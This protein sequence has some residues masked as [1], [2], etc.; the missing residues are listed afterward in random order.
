MFF[1]RKKMFTIILIVL[2]SLTMM[3]SGFVAIFSIPES[4]SGGSA[5]RESLEKEFE[6]RRQLVESISQNLEAEPE[7]QALRGALADAWMSVYAAAG[8]LG[9]AEADDALDKAL[10]L[11]AA[12]K[13]E[14][15]AVGEAEDATLITSY[16][17]AAFYKRDYALALG[18]LS[19]LTAR[20]PENVEALTLYGAC[21]FY[22]PADYAQAETLWRAA[23][24]L[25][26]DDAEREALAYY[27]DMARSAR[28]AAESAT[29][30]NN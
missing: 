1:R 13:A 16:A 23:L 22:G 6:Q 20:E 8:A 4:A 29:Q 15:E 24:A 14:A 21:L 2:V 3:G 12:L 30:E 10:E 18:L 27:A 19:D 7:N 5:E 11:Y 9:R 26:R 28:E 17:T 25:A